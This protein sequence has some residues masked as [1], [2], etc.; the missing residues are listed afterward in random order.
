MPITALVFP[1]YNVIWKNRG[2]KREYH[3]AGES[4]GF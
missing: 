3:A 1:S 4:I 2:W